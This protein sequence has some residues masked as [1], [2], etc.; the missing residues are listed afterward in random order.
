MLTQIIFLSTLLTLM[1]VS[2]TEG[3]NIDRNMAVPKD[4]IF[5][6]NNVH[7]ADPVASSKFSERVDKEG[8]ILIWNYL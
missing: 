3:G 2:I 6:L 4:K 1:F 7:P 8:T 5:N